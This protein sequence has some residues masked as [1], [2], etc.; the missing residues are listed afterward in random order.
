MINKKLFIVLILFN[1]SFSQVGLSI[2]KGII[3]ITSEQINL[4]IRVFSSSNSS[5]YLYVRDANV[6]EIISNYKQYLQNLSEESFSKNFIF[7]ENPI[8]IECNEKICSKDLY[9]RIYTKI[10]EPGYKIVFISAYQISEVERK[11]FHTVSLVPSVEMPL[12][13]FAEGN[14]I[15]KI[16]IL[17]LNVIYEEI[18]KIVIIVKNVGT[19]TSSFSISLKIENQT[20]SSFGKLKSN[21]ISILK[22]P[23]TKKGKFNVTATID[24]FSDKTSITKEI[25][26]KE[27]AIIEIK[28]IRIDIILI[29]TI[30]ILIL[31]I[32][33]KLKK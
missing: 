14:A 25:E 7:I 22:F 5:V 4:K 1:I 10:F 13:F 8:K 19:V 23:F 27:F 30:L 15:R 32:F 18:P 11:E 20:F 28:E 9:I 33:K 2:E 24:Y 31:L 16:E 29:L 3:N 26:I 6:Y 17:D 21:E 12:I